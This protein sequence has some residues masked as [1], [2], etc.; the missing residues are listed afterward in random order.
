MVPW[1]LRSSQET[2]KSTSEEP[3]MLPRDPPNCTQNKPKKAPRRSQDHL[4]IED[5]GFSKIELPPRREL[6]FS[7]SEGHLGSS[8]STS[9]S[10]KRRKRRLRRRHEP[11]KVLRKLPEAPKKPQSHDRLALPSD[12]DLPRSY[13]EHRPSC[14]PRSTDLIFAVDVVP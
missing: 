7:E 1:F 12:S 9:R 5:V 3:R 2:P 4:R 8:K 11:K 6:D 13:G 14:D 10:S